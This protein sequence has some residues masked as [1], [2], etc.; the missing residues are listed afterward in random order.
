MDTKERK[1]LIDYKTVGKK[2]QG[3]SKAHEFQLC[4]YATSLIAD[5]TEVDSIRVVYIVK[6]TIKLP[7]RVFIFEKELTNEMLMTQV[8]IMKNMEKSINVVRE[9]PELADVIFRE[10]LLSIWN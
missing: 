5:G 3:I 8:G 9:N 7:A 6:P 4:S 10:N 1:V 2:P